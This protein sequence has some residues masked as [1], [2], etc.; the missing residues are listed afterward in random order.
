MVEVKLLAYTQFTPDLKH[1]IPKDALE[2]EYVCAIAART[3]ITNE[4]IEKMLQ[5]PTEKA[6]R[7]IEKIIGYGHLSVVEHASFTFAIWDFSR[8]VSQQLTRHRIASFT[9]RGQRYV[10]VK[11]PDVVTPPTIT[12]KPELKKL[13]DEA[14]MYSYKTYKQLLDAGIP[15][16]DARFVLPNATK[17]M[18]I[19]TMNAR[20]LLHFFNLRLCARAQWEIRELAF[21]MLEQV[22]EV[23]PTIFLHAGANCMI[24]KRCI[25][26]NPPYDECRKMVRLVK[27]LKA[28][29][30]TR[31]K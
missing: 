13:F 5:I 15:K 10:K 3:A 4:S 20:E 24:G 30:I 21:K 9:Q 17:T 6:R 23:A 16:E 18:L 1:I 28:K 22:L 2:P 26:P 29:Y 8:I 14:I 7:S 25:E 11:K 27:E 12:D 31:Q 19:M